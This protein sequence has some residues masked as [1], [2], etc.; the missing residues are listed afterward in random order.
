VHPCSAEKGV[1]AGAVGDRLGLELERVGRGDAG[2]GR[3]LSLARE[4][5]DDHVAAGD[6]GLQRLG[7][8]LFDGAHAMIGRGGQNLDELAVAIGVAAQ[9]G[10]DLG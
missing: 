4:N 1:V 5:G 10:A 7:A 6:A 2:R 9:L 3:R 8:G